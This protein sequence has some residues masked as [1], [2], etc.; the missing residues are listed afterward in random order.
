MHTSGVVTFEG[1]LDRGAGSQGASVFDPNAHFENHL[2]WEFQFGAAYVRERFQAELDLQ[3]YTPVS[4]FQMLS[5]TQPSITYTDAGTGT[6]PAVTTQPFGGLTSES[7]GVVNVGLGGQYRLFEDRSLRIHGGVGSNHSP[8]GGNEVVFSKVDLTSWTL[9]V[10][11]QWA[12]F[13]F[14]AGFNHKGGTANDV[15]LRNLL[16]GQVVQTPIKV[17]TAGFI[18]SLSYQF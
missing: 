11:G 17:S 14:S 7:D 6:P 10:S 18:Y 5:S 15:T 4:T 13:Q 1:A 12:G 2:P 8:A 9:G 3:A 16:N